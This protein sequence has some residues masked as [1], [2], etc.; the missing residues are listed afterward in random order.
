FICSAVARCVAAISSEQRRRRPDPAAKLNN[1]CSANEEGYCG[2][3]RWRSWFGN[4]YIHC[5]R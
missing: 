3:W 1:D 2:E 4:C 5:K